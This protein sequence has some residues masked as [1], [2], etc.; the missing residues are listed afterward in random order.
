MYIKSCK[1]ACI[2]VLSAVAAP[3]AADAADLYRNPPAQ[4]P[5]SYAPPVSAPNTWAGFYVGINGGYGWGGGGDT[6]TEGGNPFTRATPEGGFGGG[7]VGYNFQSG[8]IVYG[9]ETDFQGGDISDSVTG[10]NNTSRER[11]DWF[12]T[13]RGRLGFALDRVLIYGTGGFAYGDVRQHAILGADTFDNAGTRTG[14]TL[15]GGVEYKLTPSWSLKA[16]Y[17]YVDFGS[18]KLSDGAGNFTS[19]L[20]TN[21]QTARIGLNY[22]F[23]GAAYEPLK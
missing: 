20:D 4:P 7:Q 17:Q 10:A 2:A 6:F 5:V 19:D 1:L 3:M 21:F 11:L 8:S 14:Y 9:V 18:E 15:G 12:G 13:A 16:E 22:R 23:G